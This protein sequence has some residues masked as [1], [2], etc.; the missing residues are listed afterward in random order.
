MILMASYGVLKKEDIFKNNPFAQIAHFAKPQFQKK[1]KFQKRPIGKI[2]QIKKK[3]I[4][5]KS[6]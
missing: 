3:L 6:Q 5:K 4:S 2:A 1:L